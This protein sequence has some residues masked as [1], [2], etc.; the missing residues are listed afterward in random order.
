MPGT[1]QRDWSNGLGLQEGEGQLDE[2]PRIFPATS[3]PKPAHD[4]QS[5]P[6]QRW[7]RDWEDMGNLER[8]FSVLWR[9]KH[10]S[11]NVVWGLMQGDSNIA[12]RAWD[13]LVGKERADFIDILRHYDVPWAPVWGTAMNIGLD[14]L[15]IV[16]GPIG[17]AKTGIKTLGKAPGVQEGVEAVKNLNIVDQLGKMFV[18][19]Y[20]TPEG[21][22][23]ALNK[24][25]YEYQSEIGKTWRSISE[26]YGDIKDTSLLKKLTDW[27]LQGNIPEGATPTELEYYHN[28]MD[29]FDKSTQ[30]AKHYG[31]ITD[32]TI[33][34]HMEKGLSTYLPSPGKGIMNHYRPGQ[35]ILGPAKKPSFALKE[36]LTRQDKETISSAFRS[37]TPLDSKSEVMT[38]AKQIAERSDILGDQFVGH[39]QSATKHLTMRGV[40]ADLHSQALQYEPIERMDI[41]Q[42]LY[43]EGIKHL[44]YRDKAAKVVTGEAGIK[45]SEGWARVHEAGQ[46]VRPGHQLLMH[47]RGLQTVIDTMGKEGLGE[48]FKVATDVAGKSPI[49]DDLVQVTKSQADFL[50]EKTG[51]R[52]LL[53]S[54]EVAQEAVDKATRMSH[55]FS[56]GEETSAIWKAYDK[57]LGPWKRWATIYRLPFHGRNFISNTA[58]MYMSGMDMPDIV[59]ELKRVTSMKLHPDQVFEIGGKS[60]T[61][62]EWMDFWSARGVRGFGW[63]DEFIGQDQ[64][65]YLQKAL[66]GNHGTIRE[67]MGKGPEFAKRAG[68]YIEDVAR[69]GVADYKLEEAV[70]KGL[71]FQEAADIGMK[72]SWKHLFQYDQLTDFERTFMKRLIPFYTWMRKNIPLQVESLI[73][74]PERFRKVSELVN[75][76]QYLSPE[77]DR[78]RELKPDYLNDVFAFRL[79]QGVTEWW[80]EAHGAKVPDDTYAWLDLPWSDLNRLP[81]RFPRGIEDFRE[82]LMEVVPS[83]TPALQVPFTEVTGV[84]PFPVPHRVERFEGELVPAP[85][86]IVGME[87]G[88][89]PVLGVTPMVDPDT[90]KKVMGMPARTRNLLE[91]LLPPV[92]ELS[93]L[94]PQAK[95]ELEEE[96]PWNRARFISGVRFAPVDRA[97]QRHYEELRKREQLSGVSRRMS[98]LGRSLTEEELEEYLDFLD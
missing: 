40:K 55:F 96:P 46:E 94:F 49:L 82:I 16:G 88:E 53:Q 9:G 6:W 77:T 79:P 87:T 81:D 15:R 56:G 66:D 76:T 8:V 47:K 95:I 37:L 83:L 13:G 35:T 22:S 85:W 62:R 43:D 91:D 68:R 50:I 92:R 73:S 45:G 1:L 11:A 75:A 59:K 63:L 29:F 30:I 4:S 48:G 19:D 58:R 93:N 72:E 97:E 78:E 84:Q 89:W 98:M 3:E 12:Q 57:L 70:Q 39:V 54:F 36:K 61:G 23:T 5:G 32:A 60:K 86:P 52:N 44:Q 80:A 90:G 65:E 69:I 42:G 21:L 7:P 41:L 51:N 14:P 27:R 17:I 20:K 2:R 26:Q 24:L 67:F 10:A 74:H 34:A 38:Q 64:A 31:A 28:M 25:E 18:H 71:S 33:E